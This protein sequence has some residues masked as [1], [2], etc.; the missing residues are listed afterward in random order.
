MKINFIL[1]NYNL[2]YY[3]I[4]ILPSQEEETKIFIFDFSSS[5]IGMISVIILLY[6]QSAILEKNLISFSSTS[7]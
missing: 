6:E 4:L 5:N 7:F 1:L 2:N 3:Q